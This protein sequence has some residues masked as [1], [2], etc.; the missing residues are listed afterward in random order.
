MS[1]RLRVRAGETA[2]LRRDGHRAAG[3]STA[4]PS[5][6]SSDPSESSKRPAQ[7]PWPS[8]GTPQASAMGAYLTL[9]GPGV[10]PD[11][12][13][14][15]PGSAMLRVTFELGKEAGNVC[16]RRYRRAPQALSGGGD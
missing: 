4:R 2:D 9:W 7:Q 11:P 8:S 13:P 10:R 14:A 1:V 12:F 3:A 5:A 16:L 15:Q 6:A